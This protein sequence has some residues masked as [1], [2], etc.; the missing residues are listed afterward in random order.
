MIID[1]LHTWIT[2]F[3]HTYTDMYLFAGES[4]VEFGYTAIGDLLFWICQLV[5]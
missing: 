1:T 4:N 5:G 3:A 2:V